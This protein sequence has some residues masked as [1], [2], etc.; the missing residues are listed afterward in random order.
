MIEL[1]IDGKNAFPRIID[2]IRH[3]EKSI[4]DK[5]KLEVYK[6]SE[7]TTK[8][9]GKGSIIVKDNTLVWDNHTF[10]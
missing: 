7:H 6:N 10:L 3:A 4:Y 5:S 2:C 8:E 1:L 9:A